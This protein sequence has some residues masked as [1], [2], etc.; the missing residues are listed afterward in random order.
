MTTLFKTW[1]DENRK[2]ICLCFTAGLIIHLQQYSTGLATPDGIWNGWGLSSYFPTGWELSLGRW[3]LFILPVL[4]SGLFSPVITSAVTI[5]LFSFGSALLTSC[6][7]ITFSPFKTILSLIIISNP[8]ISAT[9]SYYYCSDSYALAFVCAI[10]AISIATNDEAKPLL[11]PLVRVPLSSALLSVSLGIY[12]SFFGVYC[13][14]AAL[15][16]ISNLLDPSI[17]TS[18]TIRQFTILFLT[19]IVGTVLYLIILKI[20]LLASST[21]LSSYGGA[22]SI[23]ILSTIASS[24]KTIPL[25]YKKFYDL[26]FGSSMF[27]NAFGIRVVNLL[28]VAVSV[29]LLAINSQIALSRGLPVK[30]IGLAVL[31]VLLLPLA[32]N[33]IVVIAPNYQNLTNIMVG[34]FVVSLSLPLA[35]ASIYRRQTTRT[36]IPTSHSA[37]RRINAAFTTAIGIIG[38]CMIWC[39]SLQSNLDATVMTTANSRATA[40]GERIAMRLEDNTAVQN[41]AAVLI[42]GSL[43]DVWVTQ[44]QTLF[45]N[46]SSHAKWGFFWESIDGS[47]S[48]WERLI[49]DRLGARVTFCQSDEYRAIIA[50]Q[51][52]KDMPLY[53]S[54]S[55]IAMINNVVVVK[56]S[57]PSSWESASVA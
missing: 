37:P 25:A 14:V 2:T 15:V 22:S 56:V 16:M 43:D 18:K 34:G 6:L 26:L 23:G 45:S 7:R 36:S 3:G 12:Q 49:C 5:G 9:L 51:E 44:N 17:K 52:F 21:Q 13:A 11:R 20:V 35:L 19:L 48:I 1:L 53:P 41:G 8:F 33:S 42:A 24:P 38:I 47:R 10:A 40:V 4:K 57:D 54:E 28:G 50:S 32:A 29:L 27:G 46:A 30:R 31:F 55:S 39:Y